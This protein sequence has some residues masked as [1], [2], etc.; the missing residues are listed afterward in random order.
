[1]SDMTMV[2]V[3]VVSV[4]AFVAV[5][6]WFGRSPEFRTVRHASGPRQPIPVP[7]RPQTS[8]PQP[9][10]ASPRPSEPQPLRM[11]PRGATNT[12]PEHREPA[13]ALPRTIT[14]GA[15]E[16]ATVWAQPPPSAEGDRQISSRKLDSPEPSALPP[17]K[18]PA[19]RP[20]LATPS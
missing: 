5:V 7:V 14:R 18:T 19:S 2:V 17:L 3:G 9:V 8:V 16:Q 6:T 20:E 1:M 15:G 13:F 4:L 10:S 12:L 11:P